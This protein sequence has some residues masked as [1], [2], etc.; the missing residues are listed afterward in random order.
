M[1]MNM[2]SSTKSNGWAR[3]NNGWA[4]RQRPRHHRH[5]LTLE[6]A[7]ICCSLSA[8]VAFTIYGVLHTRS[9]NVH[10]YHTAQNWYEDTSKTSLPRRNTAL[11]RIG[12]P[13]AS[14]RY[15]NDTIIL[16]SHHGVIEE[17]VT[18]EGR[19]PSAALSDE[20]SL[21]SIPSFFTPVDEQWLH[22][23]R[24]VRELSHRILSRNIAQSNVMIVSP[25][26]GNEAH[27]VYNTNTNKNNGKSY[28]HPQDNIDSTILERAQRYYHPAK[29]AIDQGHTTHLIPTSMKFANGWHTSTDD[30]SH[31]YNSTSVGWILLAYFAT[32]GLDSA[33]S[34]RSSPTTTID[35]ILTTSNDNA[36]Q[37][38]LSHTT[39]TYMV[40]PI[41][42]K[43]TIP[44]S[45]ILLNH[46]YEYEMDYTVD[47]TVEVTGLVAAQTLLDANYKLQLLSSSHYFDEVG[48]EDGEKE[49]SFHYGPN[50]LFMTVKALHRFLY[51]RAAHALRVE[52][53]HIRKK[54]QHLSGRS[55]LATNVTQQQH[56]EVHFHA[57]I[58]ATQGLDLAISSRS[59]YVD[60]GAHK[61]CRDPN[62]PGGRKERCDPKL[63]ARA[64]NDTI[65][66]ECPKRHNSLSVQFVDDKNADNMRKRR[67][68]ER[69]E[70]ESSNGIMIDM[71]GKWLKQ[72]GVDT[73]EL[74]V[75]KGD[76]NP[77]LT[78]ALCVK[79]DKSSILPRVSCIT[80]V[81]P[82]E[83]KSSPSDTA[84]LHNAPSEP[85]NLLVIMIDPLSRQQLKRSLPNTWALLELLGF[86]DFPRYTA[87]GNN[88]GPNQAALYS[89]LPLA[90]RQD[91]RSSSKSTERIWLWDRLKDAGYMTMKAEDGCISNST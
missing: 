25:N 13:G 21:Q 40:F 45:C 14:S 78:E 87:V 23:G 43:A 74:E 46:E 53:N 76:E 38:W 50:A 80:R 83:A 62:I 1:N 2:N 54:Q 15:F 3:K 56:V 55:L 89:G 20:H 36:V 67:I 37:S 16:Q 28:Y 81:V 71:D 44:L 68:Y 65:F 60:V 27:V 84:A 11:R 4:P 69:T 48:G 64:F 91:I 51:Q 90:A 77:R 19:A 66:L 47:K 42:A 31:H 8:I 73:G 22:N 17:I 12:R 85:P 59:S 7:F 75:W 41:S 52:V 34:S 79:T 88:S 24:V 72:A 86:I 29:L 5:T 58:F 26:F 9:N 30:G 10:V 35:D 32:Q 49:G 18:N 33:S 82:V 63:N 70:L 61:E 57:L 39:I 6:K